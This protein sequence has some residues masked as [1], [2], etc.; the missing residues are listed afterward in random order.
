MTTVTDP[1]NRIDSRQRADVLA[2]AML[3][4]APDPA[5]RCWQSTTRPVL[6]DLLF[7]ASPGQTGGG[8]A[9]V[10]RA[11]AAWAG[12]GADAADT[13]GR[14]G[15][16]ARRV[17]SRLDGQPDRAAMLDTLRRAVSPWLG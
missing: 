2:Y 8:M 17:L 10:H 12:D 3:R 1:T 15:P 11:L 14:C 4:L 16:E 6:G 13:V 7:A 5:P 9:W